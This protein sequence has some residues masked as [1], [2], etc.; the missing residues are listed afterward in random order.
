MKTQSIDR[1]LLAQLR[2]RNVKTAFVAYS[3]GNDD[4]GCDDVKLTLADDTEVQLGN[5][6]VSTADGDWMLDA[7]GRIIPAGTKVTHHFEP[8]AV[9]SR[10]SYYRPA[11][12]QQID[13]FE[14][15]Q[16]LCQPVNDRY[17]SWAGDFEA[18]G[19]L[20]YDVETG[21][22]EINAFESTMVETDSW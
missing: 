2:A 6:Y 13:D 11:T 4:G 10:R 12:E 21:E 22:L 16:A 18:H 3:G 5:A 8:L 7:D 9:G 19:D 17:G 14:L 1:A 20:T 15:T